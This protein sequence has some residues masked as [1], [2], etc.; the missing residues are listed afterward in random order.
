[1]IKETFCAS[2]GHQLL[3]SIGLPKVNCDCTVRG[4]YGVFFHMQ[5]TSIAKHIVS[6]RLL[7]N[8]DI[9][10]QDTMGGN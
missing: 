8:A 4:F 2:Y 6:H 7:E 10:I 9:E 3:S 5:N 1:M